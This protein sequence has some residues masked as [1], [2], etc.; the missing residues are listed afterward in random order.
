MLTFRSNLVDQSLTLVQIVFRSSNIFDHWANYNVMVCIACRASVGQ[1]TIDVAVFMSQMLLTFE[2]AV[3]ACCVSVGKLSTIQV[4]EFRECDEA[5]W[6]QGMRQGW[7]RNYMKLLGGW[8]FL[9][10]QPFFDHD[11]LLIWVISCFSLEEASVFLSLD[12]NWKEKVILESNEYSFSI[13]GVSH[14]DLSVVVEEL[15]PLGRLQHIEGEW[16]HEYSLVG[17]LDN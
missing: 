2:R 9:G 17:Q 3:E 11:E 8:L 5:K 1:S 6:V 4:A 12:S 7:S 14:L 16:L 10:F 13:H 15:N